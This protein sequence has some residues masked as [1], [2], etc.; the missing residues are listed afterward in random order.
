MS[1]LQLAFVKLAASIPPEAIQKF[2]IERQKMRILNQPL[3]HEQTPML[4]SIDKNIYTRY[5]RP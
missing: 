3:A 5:V 2:L 4:D 1:N